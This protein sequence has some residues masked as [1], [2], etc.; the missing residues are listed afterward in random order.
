MR[1]VRYID[2]NSQTVWGQQLKNGEIV[3][4]A[5]SPNLPDPRNPAETSASA[6]VER[7]V[8][9]VVPPNIF[10]IG[11]NYRRHAQEM[12]SQLPEHPMV[13]MKPTTAVI[14][15]GEAIRIPA[16]SHGP[17][18]DYEC[19]LA[20]IISRA[21]REVSEAKA[22][23]YVYGYTCAIDVSARWWQNHGSGGQF[24]RGKGFDTFCP[25]GPAIVTA[26]EI[27]DPQTLDI[28][29][30][31]NGQVMQQSNTGDMVFSVAELI[32]RLSCDTTIL[33]GTVI[34]TGT[35]EGVGAGRDPQVFLKDG[36]TVTV[37]VQGIGEL[38][39]PVKG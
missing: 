34:L 15:P 16:C 10:G 26:D 28:R 19:E 30:T 23:D 1:I 32:S 31:L 38:T 14:G 11:L 5:D 24:T 4:L 29:T 6:R 13:F 2:G 33:P 37:E 20:V 7:L 39:N 27:P 12:G 3:P 18:V 25:L 8:A 21:C 17:E 35:P 22:L 36:D 9:P